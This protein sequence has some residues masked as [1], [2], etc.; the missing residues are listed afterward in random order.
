MILPPISTEQIVNSQHFFLIGN[1]VLIGS[2]VLFQW[3]WIYSALC[4]KNFGMQKKRFSFWF[5]FSWEGKCFLHLKLSE[6]TEWRNRR[7]QVDN[8]GL[9][10]FTSWFGWLP[11]ALSVAFSD[12]DA[13]T[14]FS[15]RANDHRQHGEVYQSEYQIIF[16]LLQKFLRFSLWNNGDRKYCG[17]IETRIFSHRTIP[18]KKFCVRTFLRQCK[19][20]AAQMFILT[21]THLSMNINLVEALNNFNRR[22]FSYSRE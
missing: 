4:K 20:E 2:S 15:L 12:W 16:W 11:K 1:K 5:V 6:V 8:E 10:K 19:L 17:R 14:V 22:I 13:L 7:S 18:L 9:L 3:E 21:F